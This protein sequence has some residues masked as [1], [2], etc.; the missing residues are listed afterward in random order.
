VR[1]GGAFASRSPGRQTPA[2]VASRAFGLRDAS[3]REFHL[4]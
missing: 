1:P 3:G 2:E 4:G